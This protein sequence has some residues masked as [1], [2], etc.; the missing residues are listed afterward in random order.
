MQLVSSCFFVMCEQKENTNIIFQGNK[1]DWII[2]WA[3][4]GSIN[5]NIRFGKKIFNRSINLLR[6]KL[7]K[8]DYINFKNTK[9]SKL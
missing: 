2:Y 1:E 4:V 7:T 5:E 9:S 6:K 8:Y 3:N